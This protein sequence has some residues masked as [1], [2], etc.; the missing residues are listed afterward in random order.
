MTSNIQYYL[1]YN[2]PIGKRQDGTV[3]YRNGKQTLDFSQF[4]LDANKDVC[5][6]MNEMFGDNTH[7]VEDETG[8]K[9]YL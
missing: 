5:D 7:W 1:C 8:E 9:V 4:D 2:A 3:V 6:S